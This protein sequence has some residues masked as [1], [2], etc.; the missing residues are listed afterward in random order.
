MIL[1]LFEVYCFTDNDHSVWRGNAFDLFSEGYWVNSRSRH[2][3]S[4]LGCGFLVLLSLCRQCLGNFLRLG[5]YYF[6]PHSVQ[7][8][9]HSIIILKIQHLPSNYISRYCILTMAQKLHFF[10]ARKWQNRFQEGELY[11]LQLFYL[12]GNNDM[13]F[14]E[15]QKKRFGGTFCFHLHVE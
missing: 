12:L 14:D 2:W 11:L 8:N 5:N 7:F 13:L 3:L 15:S 4:L 9:M 6:Y 10:E 1:C